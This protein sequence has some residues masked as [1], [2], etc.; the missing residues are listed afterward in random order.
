MSHET[1]A[2]IFDTISDR[3]QG[4]GGSLS[5]RTTLIGLFSVYCDMTIDQQNGKDAS[6]LLKDHSGVKDKWQTFYEF[7][8]FR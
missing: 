6:V 1:H 8:L 7:D 2:M 4:T 5:C 3:I